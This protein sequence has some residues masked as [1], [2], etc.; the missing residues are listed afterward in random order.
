MEVTAEQQAR[1]IAN[2]AH[3]AIAVDPKNLTPE[4]QT[5][6]NS[7]IFFYETADDFSAWLMRGNYATVVFK[8]RL[9]ILIG[10]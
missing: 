4:E 6:L 8:A 7:T 10:C 9:T 1:V 3:N 2:I 5:S